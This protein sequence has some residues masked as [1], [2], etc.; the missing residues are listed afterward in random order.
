MKVLNK[1]IFLQN[2]LGLKDLDF[3]RRYKI[4]LNSFK[5]WKIFKK[6]PKLKDISYLIDSFN[7]DQN[8]FMNGNS[9]L[10]DKLEPHEHSCKSKPST[11]E[12]KNLVYEDFAREENGRYEE[13]D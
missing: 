4:K 8:D 10:S 1:I 12:D 9:S 6:E 13:K 7:L 2:S 5:L 3:C 11:I